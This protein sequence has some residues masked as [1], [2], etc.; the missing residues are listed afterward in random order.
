MN[1]YPRDY[2]FYNGSA[3][4]LCLCLIK[5]FQM[6]RQHWK[7]RQRACWFVCWP[8]NSRGYFWMMSEIL[9]L[10]FTFQEVINVPG[11]DISKVGSLLWSRTYCTN[12]VIGANHN[13]ESHC[14]CIAPTSCVYKLQQNRS[15]PNTQG[16]NSRCS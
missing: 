3:E 2:K 13:N 12:L 16:K 15:D 9:L 14:V 8:M 1:I 10:S 4:V 11:T 5:R 7:V 6:L